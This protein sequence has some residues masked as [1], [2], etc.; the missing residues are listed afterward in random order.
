[1]LEEHDPI[2]RCGVGF[3][4]CYFLFLQLYVLNLDAV[5]IAQN[6]HIFVC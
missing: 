5:T 4:V 2:T 6:R 1:M 3:C